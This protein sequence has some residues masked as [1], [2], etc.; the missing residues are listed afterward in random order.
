MNWISLLLVKREM[1]LALIQHSVSLHSLGNTNVCDCCELESHLTSSDV[2]RQHVSIIKPFSGVQTRVYSGKRCLV[3]GTRTDRR[4]FP[5]DYHGFQILLSAKDRNLLPPTH[6]PRTHIFTHVRTH[7]RTHT[8]GADATAHYPQDKEK[9]Q[10]HTKRACLHTCTQCSYIDIFISEWKR[11]NVQ[12]TFH[13]NIKIKNKSW[14]EK[15]RFLWSF[16]I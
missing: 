15:S 16:D 10:L 14:N 13:F 12:I 11:R 8:Q 3:K 4:V 7:S 5:F 1:E 2:E 9:R 6:T